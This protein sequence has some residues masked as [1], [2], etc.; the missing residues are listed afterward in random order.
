MGHSRGVYGEGPSQPK[1][2]ACAGTTRPRVGRARGELLNGSPAP[3]V[4]VMPRASVV[5]LSPE[6]ICVLGRD[7]ARIKLQGVYERKR[8]SEGGREREREG[9]KEG[10]TVGGMGLERERMRECA[11]KNS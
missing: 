6:S 1:E 2:L 11:R 7:T 5:N 4:N 9:G 10:G 8:A 3:G